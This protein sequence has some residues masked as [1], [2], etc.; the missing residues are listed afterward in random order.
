MYKMQKINIIVEMAKSLCYNE[1]N[2]YLLCY[3]VLFFVHFA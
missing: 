2:G 3:F 1:H